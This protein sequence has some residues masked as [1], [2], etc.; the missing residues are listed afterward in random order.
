[1]EILICEICGQALA[2]FDPKKV[3]LPLRADMFEEINSDLGLPPSWNDPS[4]HE[5]RCFYP[6]PPF[7]TGFDTA[8]D[9]DPLHWPAA[10]KTPDGFH[11]IR[12]EGASLKDSEHGKDTPSGDFKCKYCG[13]PYQIEHWCRKHEAKCPFKMQ[14]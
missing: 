6:H 12:K 14:S 3:S 5:W 8:E 9:G 13:K 10:L 4:I 2:R 7:I 11:K 1:M